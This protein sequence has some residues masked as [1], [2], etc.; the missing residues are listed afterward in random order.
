[1]IVGRWFNGIGELRRVVKV[2]GLLTPEY[3]LLNSQG[4]LLRQM[5]FRSG[6]GVQIIKSL[7]LVKSWV[8]RWAWNSL[9]YN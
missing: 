6:R 8:S 7:V 4:D 3:E 1:M 9:R 5:D 2:A